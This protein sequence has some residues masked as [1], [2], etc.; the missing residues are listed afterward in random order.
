M[1]GE[2]RMKNLLMILILAFSFCYAGSDAPDLKTEDIKKPEPVEKTA[3]AKKIAQTEKQQVK[4]DQTKKE[5]IQPKTQPAKPAPAQ[6]TIP[7]ASASK[8]EAGE[9]DFRLGTISS[10]DRSKLISLDE[11]DKVFE[12]DTLLTGKESRCEIKLT[13]GS[14]VRLSENTKY[15]IDKY[16]FSGDK[17]NFQGYLVSGESWTNVNKADSKKK[18]FKVRSPIAV[19]AVLGTAYKMTADGKLTEISVMEGQVEVDLEEE[20]KAELKIEPKKSSG[21]LAPKQT[22]GPKE[23]PGPYEVTLSEWISIVKG[24]MISIRSDGKYNKTKTDVNILINEWE[25]FNKR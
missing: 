17:V 5:V 4:K 1:T 11:E 8:R 18:D 15:I 19:A 3:P 13:D 23:I 20:K 6:K 25:G 12:K 7:A 24:E 21:S 22:T 14:I 2:G 9:I 10:K 16:E